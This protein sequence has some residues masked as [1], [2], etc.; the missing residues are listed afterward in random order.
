MGMAWRT[1]CGWLGTVRRLTPT[2]ACVLGY[3]IAVASCVEVGIR[4]LPLRM[5]S[6]LAGISLVTAPSTT[7]ALKPALTTAESRAVRLAASVMRRWPLGSGTCLRRSLVIG[8]F[9]R[10]LEPTLRIGVTR[11]SG[12]ISA[13]AWLE[14]PGAVNV[15]GQDHTPFD[16]Q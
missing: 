16:L 10:R 3:V 11:D 15:G 2:E 9:V 6:R 8:Y 7:T 4:L 1:A 5:V 13:H 14:V 12:A